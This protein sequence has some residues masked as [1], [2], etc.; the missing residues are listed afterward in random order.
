MWKEK[1]KE[2]PQTGWSGSIERRDRMKV[3]DKV[4]K[5]TE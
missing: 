4:S 3:K 2:G 1:E 5:G